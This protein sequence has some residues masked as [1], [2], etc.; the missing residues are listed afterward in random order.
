[1]AENLIYNP[2][3]PYDSNRGCPTREVFFDVG[4]YS[5]WM[6]APDENMGS[7]NAPW[8][9]STQLT[10]GLNATVSSAYEG[11]TYDLTW[12]F[13]RED[14]ATAFRKLFS[15][16]GN[17]P[18]FFL[19]PFASDNILSPFLATPYLHVDSMTPLAYDDSGL[20][21]ATTGTGIV[22]GMPTPVF[23]GGGNSVSS[24]HDYT[25]RIVVP[26]DK[27]LVIDAKGSPGSGITVNG[28]MLTN[29]EPVTFNGPLEVNVTLSASAPQYDLRNVV[30]QILP[31]HEPV[32]N[33]LPE[34][35]GLGGGNLRVVPGSAVLTPVNKVLGIYAASISLTEVWAW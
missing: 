21:I 26:E 27:Y 12:S 6:P 18:V 15:N 24:K 30:A 4:G 10:N 2:R 28:E 9:A 8:G 20:Q 5:S 23:T 29:N 31:M 13:L 3:L 11:K 17:K 22:D 7:A 33:T 35:H 34:K 14:G 1:M 16:A 25:E 19:D 32:P